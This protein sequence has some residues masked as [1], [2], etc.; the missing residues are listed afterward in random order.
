MRLI[1]FLSLFLLFGC[2]TKFERQK[3]RAEKFYNEYPNEFAIKAAEKFPTKEIFIKGKDIIIIDSIFSVDTLRSEV[4]KK[5]T[6]RITKVINKYINRTDTILFENTANIK[7]LGNRISKLEYDLEAEKNKLSKSNKTKN[8][9]I[10]ISVG[11]FVLL[12]GGL[13]YL[14]RSKVYSLV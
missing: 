8:I 1:V 13:L 7:T 5:D 10:Y 11:L 3:I 4:T 12:I 14:L 9:F 6:L 2:T